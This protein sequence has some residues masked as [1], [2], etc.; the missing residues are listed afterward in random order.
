MI[1]LLSSTEQGYHN[2]PLSTEQIRAIAP[3]TVIYAP[4]G[5]RR[6]AALAGIDP[7]SDQYVNWLRAQMLASMDALCS[8]NV[9]HVFQGL[10]RSTHFAER[11]AYRE[12]LFKWGEWFLTGP[13]AIEDWQRRG[14]RVRLTGVEDIPEMQAVAETLEA[15][16]PPHAD[17]TI[18]F[19]MYA[20]LDSQWT[21]I[22]K[23]LQHLDHPT[24][25]ALIQATYGEKIPPA[26]MYISSGKTLIAP[27]ALPILLMDEMHCYWMQRPGYALDADMLGAMIYDAMHTRKTWQAD[28][29]NRYHH[30]FEQRDLLES[31]RIIGLGHRI[32]PFWYPLF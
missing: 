15:I 7:H 18:W 14:W 22:F 19:Y 16:T 2:V 6:Q 3:E 11:S 10:L 23:T 27:D 25:E 31:S 9:K 13:E 29:T 21:T 32:G 20:S 28:K 30:V 12:R 24:R 17:F 5:T 8:V 1:D 26:S 4:G